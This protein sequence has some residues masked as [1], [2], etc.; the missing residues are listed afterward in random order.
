MDRF[1][2]LILLV[3]PVCGLVG[4]IQALP[5]RAPQFV[6]CVGPDTA[7]VYETGEVY[8]LDAWGEVVES[9]QPD[10]QVPFQ[11]WS[12]AAGRLILAYSTFEGGSRLTILE[13]PER[14]RSRTLVLPH[15]ILRPL[16]S[17]SPG[18]SLLLTDARNP[19]VLCRWDSLSWEYLVPPDGGVVVDAFLG[20][21]GNTVMTVGSQGVV[22]YLDLAT[23][24]SRLRL[25]LRSTMGVLA[26]SPD[27]ARMALADRGSLQ[28][29]DRL[30]GELVWRRTVDRELIW[31]VDPR[32]D[33]WA[34]P[35]DRSGRILLWEW[36]D[37]GGLNALELTGPSGQPRAFL[38]GGRQV[39]FAEGPFLHRW[40]DGRLDRFGPNRWIVRADLPPPVR[41]SRY[42]FGLGEPTSVRSPSG[43][44]VLQ[45]RVRLV[46]HLSGVYEW[47]RLEDGTL[48][49]VDPTSDGVVW[50]GRADLFAEVSAQEVVLWHQARPRQLAIQTIGGP[51]SVALP[52]PGGEVRS[53]RFDPAANALYL[54]SV[55]RDGPRVTVEVVRLQ[56]PRWRMVTVWSGTLPAIPSLALDFEGRPL[57]WPVGRGYLSLRD[58]TAHPVDQPRSVVELRPDPLGAWVRYVD[59]SVALIRPETGQVLRH[60]FRLSGGEEIVFEDRGRG[61]EVSAGGWLLLQNR[62]LAWGPRPVVPPLQEASLPILLPRHLLLHELA[63]PE[64]PDEESHPAAAEEPPLSESH[65]EF[66]SGTGDPAS[67]REPPVE[68]RTDTP[69]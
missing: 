9:L 63:K 55:L 39:V 26:V 27:R 29:F 24:Q 38:P 10:G 18:R 41:Q 37:A 2:W 52:L 7:L 44:V 62:L 66:R 47:F 12:D 13:P 23:R 50:R 58:G 42:R 36:A 3:V 69:P 14:A 17:H 28:V 35:T 4:A 20:E 30:T 16:V 15:K 57:L 65:S 43:G 21:R 67:E 40:M 5:E 59:G 6:V 53:L 51:E 64:Q 56:P 34:L 49:A 61:L 45:S 46:E 11:A 1:A 54:L 19:L 68:V 8:L 25:D 60:L 48:F 33:L 32:G 22:H 31:R